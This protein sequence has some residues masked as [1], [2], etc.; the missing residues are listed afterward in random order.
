MAGHQVNEAGA[1]AFCQFSGYIVGTDNPAIIM[2]GEV[3]HES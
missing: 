2:L 3:N 1:V